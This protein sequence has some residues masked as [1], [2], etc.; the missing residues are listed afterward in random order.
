MSHR[1]GPDTCDVDGRSMV[2]RECDAKGGMF[3]APITKDATCPHCGET[4]EPPRDER[5]LELFG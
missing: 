3:K 1:V 4:V 2:W 5:Q